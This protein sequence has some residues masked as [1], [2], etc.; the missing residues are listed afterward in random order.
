MG[1]LAPLKKLQNDT[2]R[3]IYTY[4]DDVRGYT[5]K[6]TGNWEKE[7]HEGFKTS[8]DRAS[9]VLKHEKQS[10]FWILAEILDSRRDCLESVK[11]EDTF[12]GK[13]EGY[14]L[15]SPIAGGGGGGSY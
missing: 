14:V 9:Q 6:G 5:L 10:G 8:K 11:K 7:S 15:S 2:P 12:G 13:R 1:G 4:H 3:D